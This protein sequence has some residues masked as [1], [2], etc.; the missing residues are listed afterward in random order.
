MTLAFSMVKT[1]PNFVGGRAWAETVKI[2]FNSEDPHWVLAPTQWL[3]KHLSTLASS[4]LIVLFSEMLKISKIISS[5]SKNIAKEN[6]EYLVFHLL[7]WMF[8]N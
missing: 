7:K 3:S 6:S 8:Q 4:T 2:S 5:K 1:C